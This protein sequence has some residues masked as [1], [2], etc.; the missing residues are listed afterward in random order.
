MAHTVVFR[1]P[2]NEEVEMI[3]VCGGL[4][5]PVTELVCAR[6]TDCGYPYRLLDL[7]VYPVGFHVNWHW[8]GA[9]PTGTIASARW[10]LD[11]G[12]L[13]GV[14]VR[15]LGAEG[16]VPP[17][18]I[19]PEFAA[20]VS[21]E[22]DTG[23]AAVLEYLPCPVV[24]RLGGGMSNHSKPYQALL[25]RR[26]GLRTPSTLVTNAP[27]VA[28]RFYEECNGAVIYK[29]LSGV[30]SIVRRMDAEHLA[31]LPLL[32]HGPAQFQAFIPGENVRVH[33]VGDQWF[34][35]RVHSEAVDYRYAHLDGHSVAMEPTTLPP[36]VATACLRLA[37]QLGLLLAGIDLKETPEGAYYCFEINPS[38]GFLYYE[39]GSGQPISTTLADLLHHGGSR[40]AQGE[41]NPMPS[42]R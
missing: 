41:E 35:T 31:R 2:A 13:R 18:H 11:L 19:A 7:G 32:R 15:Y 6:L 9:Y 5:D 22:C 27:E 26:C 10:R 39:Q 21:M 34:A 20:A 17:P 16:R 33:T 37:H 40:N 25:V 12:E 30:R 36:A 4:A 14:Y 29:S 28:R 1:C 42:A 38:P 8:Q 3:L 24:N 23:L